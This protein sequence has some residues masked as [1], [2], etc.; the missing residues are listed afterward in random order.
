LT[1]FAYQPNATNC[2]CTWTRASETGVPYLCVGGVDGI[3]KIYDLVNGT[4]AGVRCRSPPASSNISSTTT[5][6]PFPVTNILSRT[7]PAMEGS[8]EYYLSPE[9]R[10]IAHV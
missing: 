5:L 10:H 1:S 7:S 4:L 3:V 9:A 2:C 6:D 8:V